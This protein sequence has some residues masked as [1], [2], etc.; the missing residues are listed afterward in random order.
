VNRITK[1]LQYLGHPWTKWVKAN[2]TGDMAPDWGNLV[3][4]GHS[5]GADNAA[6]LAKT[7]K[8]S[9]V[10]LFAGA[11]DMV[12]LKHAGEDTK[13]APW[14]YMQG[15]TPPERIYGFGICGTAVHP[16]S[17]I[18]HNWRPGWEAQQMP[19]RF[20]R[21]DSILGNRSAMAGM[22]KLCSNGSKVDLKLSNHMAS[23]GDCCA[24]K[25]ADG[26][27]RVFG[28]NLALE[29]AIPLGSPL[30][31]VVIINYVETRR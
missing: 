28:Q 10:L 4:A 16:A 13:P 24:P 29:D 5:N 7:F 30:L 9:R 25:Y 3:I 31:T 22:H 15:A 26:M 12:G 17:G 6:F 8:V 21:V 14:Q 23:A 2:S 27:V 1:A 11:N 18:C 19:G 20:H